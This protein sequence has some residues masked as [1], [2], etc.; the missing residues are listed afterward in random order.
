MFQGF[1]PK[2]GI[3][4]RRAYCL[5]NEQ[6]RAGLHSTVSPPDGAQRGP[7]EKIRPLPCSNLG[8][9]PQFLNFVVRIPNKSH[10]QQILKI[11]WKNIHFGEKYF[12]KIWQK[13][14][15]FAARWRTSS[16]KF[17][18][19]K[20]HSRSVCSIFGRAVILSSTFIRKK[21]F[22]PLPPN[23]RGA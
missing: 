14:T 8:A 5:V 12:S 13:F 19:I 15:F 16:P 10:P 20:H 9:D 7:V 1:L 21:P 17:Q 3:C 11:S 6:K 18:K 4:C 22:S 23:G 2:A